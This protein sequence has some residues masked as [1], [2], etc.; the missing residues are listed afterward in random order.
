[1]LLLWMGS[2]VL[3]LCCHHGRGSSTAAVAEQKVDLVTRLDVIKSAIMSEKRHGSS[4]VAQ[5]TDCYLCTVRLLRRLYCVSLSPPDK[6]FMTVVGAV[7]DMM[8]RAI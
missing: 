1:M 2:I 8:S 7:D 3:Q 6:Y 5:F 4:K